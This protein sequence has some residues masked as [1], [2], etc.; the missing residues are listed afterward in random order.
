MNY[1]ILD[2]IN[3]SHLDEDL[4]KE[5]TEE[6]DLDLSEFNIFMLVKDDEGKVKQILFKDAYPM[7]SF[8]KGIEINKEIDAIFNCKPY[9]DTVNDMHNLSNVIGK[10]HR[11]H[12][13]V[14]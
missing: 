2:F 11:E 6:Y 3:V 10:Y 1:K 14:G 7:T 12:P 4:Q 9:N 13:T 5:L 8:K